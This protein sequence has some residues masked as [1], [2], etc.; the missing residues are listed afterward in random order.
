MK[1]GIISILIATCMIVLICLLVNFALDCKTETKHNNN[2]PET[3][4]YHKTIPVEITEIKKTWSSNR[5]NSWCIT[6]KSKEYNL[7]K[8]FNQSC[9]F[10]HSDVYAGKLYYGQLEKGDTINATLLSWKQGD[11]IIRRDLDGLVE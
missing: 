10:M 9:N 7:E 11:K 4:M 5:E 1:K 6:V 8:S 2:Q 3:S